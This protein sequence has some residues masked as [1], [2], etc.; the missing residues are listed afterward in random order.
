VDLSTIDPGATFG[1]DKDASPDL[2]ENDRVR[3][4][5]LQERLWASKGGPV[6]IVLQGIDTA[7][8]DGT[9]RHVMTAFNPQGCTVTGFGVPTDDELAHDYL[10]RIHRHTPARGHIAIFNRSHYEDVLVVRVHD[11]V[12]EEVW[13][14]RYDQINAFERHLGDNGTTI[15]KF[16]LWISR[17]E[18][19]ERLQARID[20]PDKR[21]KFKRADLDERA[22]WPDY[23][24]A[25]EEALTRCSTDVA[26]WYVVPSDRKWFRNVAVAEILTD[27][28]EGLRLDYPAAEEGI[29]SLKVE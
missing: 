26:P 2:L 6:L 3:L 12:P 23:V 10:W 27:A 15:L 29:E 1:H 14:S 8:K 13:R 7:G 25:Y 5:S 20:T 11:L 18:Q 16:F 22:R 28:M 9:V 17:E 4:E 19:R 21:W 24:A